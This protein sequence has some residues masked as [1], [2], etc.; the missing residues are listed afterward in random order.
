MWKVLPIVGR[1]RLGK[2]A[3]DLWTIPVGRQAGVT[4]SGLSG[5]TASGFVGCW[6]GGSQRPPAV[7]WLEAKLVRPG[8]HSQK[9][10]NNFA[11]LVEGDWQTGP[12]KADNRTRCPSPS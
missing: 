2:P 1:N 4:S 10:G 8:A 3:F 11:N 5:T 9:S 7:R 6:V 12:L